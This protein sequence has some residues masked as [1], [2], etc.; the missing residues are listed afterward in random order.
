MR[1]GLRP[2]G[3]AGCLPSAMNETI[4]FI[5]VGDQGGPMAHRIIESGFPL[6]VW[7][8]RSEV[9][10]AYTAKGASAA[11][12][13]A[14]LGS[15]CDHVGICVFD[16]DAVLEVASQLIPSMKAGSRIVV[17]S[18]VLP[19]TVVSLERRC[20]ERDIMLLDAPVA[21]GSAAAEA[22]T[23]TLM[24]GGRP[25]AF[26]AALPVLR[27]F[28]EQIALLGPTG[29]GQRAKI[30]TNA[31]FSAHMGIALAALDAAA[32][33]GVSRT[34]LVELIRGGSAGSF[35]F[36][37]YAELPSPQAF[38]HHARNLLKDL[39]LLKSVLPDHE[40][41]RELDAASERFLAQAI[42]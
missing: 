21:G 37:V 36:E 24:C 23:L 1:D 19:E 34:Q 14:D 39:N 29:S 25:E 4:G 40:A 26:S 22:G 2:G 18:T 15:R 17:H 11:A 10:T 7:A 20:A 41:T 32:A 6:V 5:G 13:A 16:D 42:G 28:G 30:I 8:R 27:T 33:M 38:A 3:A 12:S 35:G 31:V 9:L